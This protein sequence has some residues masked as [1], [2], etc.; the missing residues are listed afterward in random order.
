MGHVRIWLAMSY[1]SICAM[2][3]NEAPYLREWVAF[4]RLMGVER[5]YLY[6]NE[7]T[8]DH[9]EALA[10]FI[11]EGVVT[12]T[13]MPGWPVQMQVYDD[14][15]RR[16]R[17]ESRWIAFIDIDEF[18]FSPAGGPVADVMRGY[19]PHPGVVVNWAVFGNSGHDEPP[20]GLVL[21][22]YTRRSDSEGWNRHIKA[23]VDPR[24]VAHF[25]G[26]HIFTYREGGPVDERGRPLSRPRRTF[27]DTV[28]FDRLRLNHYLTRSRREYADKLRTVWPGIEER[29]EQIPARVART[30][31]VLDEVEDRSIQVHVPAL[32]RALDGLSA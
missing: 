1:L 14:C 28:S 16:H 21:E 23:I 22:N 24:R 6:D 3:R 18:L 27:T 30:L 19:E 20:G 8:D 5:F 13:E 15:L 25:C 29:A 17:D 7:S 26:P 10:P 9:R 31:Q 4:H 11:D 32:K 2:Y 12:V